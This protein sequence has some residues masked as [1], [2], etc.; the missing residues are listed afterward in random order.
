MR[1]SG[2]WR[3]LRTDPVQQLRNLGL[4]AD[5]GREGVDAAPVALGDV[6]DYPSCVRVG[7]APAGQYDVTGTELGQIRRGVQTDRAE[8]TGDQI[9]PIGSRLQPVRY[10]QHDLPDVPRLLHAAERGPGL[11]ERVDLG[12]EWCPVAAGDPVRPLR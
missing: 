3:Q 12:G 1:H 6:V 7:R 8:S 10:L 9:A 11:R 4:V 5:V 2:E